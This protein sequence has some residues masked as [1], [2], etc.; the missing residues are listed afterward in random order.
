[1][2]QM[3][4]S[5]VARGG[6]GDDPRDEGCRMKAGMKTELRPR[7][8]RDLSRVLDHVAPSAEHER[9]PFHMPAGRR[10]IKVLGQ[11]RRRC[12][13]QRGVA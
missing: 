11:A 2:P 6:L 9:C 10:A 8:W 1:M 4:T 5:V 7:Y 13:Q 3:H 12:G